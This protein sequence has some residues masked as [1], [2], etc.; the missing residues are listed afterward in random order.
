[1]PTQNIDLQA[2]SAGSRVK[3]AENTIADS[4]QP[5]CHDA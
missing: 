5:R 2:T 3:N 1:M 4:P